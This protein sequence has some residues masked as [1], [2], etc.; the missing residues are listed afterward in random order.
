MNWKT[1]IVSCTLLAFILISCD[2]GDAVY[3][4]RPR[5][6][7][8]IDF[9]DKKYQKLNE[10]CPFNFE[11]PVYARAKKYERKD[12]QPCWYNIEFPQF[13]ATIHLSYKP[14]KKNIA[15]YIDTSHYF[16]KTHQ[17]RAT[18][19]EETVVIR[20]SAKVYGLLFSID[21]NVAS[22]LQF[23][24][25]DSTR[26]FLRGSL[27]FNSK[28]NIDSIKVVLDFLKKDILHLINT[29]QWKKD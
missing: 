17:S 11:I 25:T 7:F 19:I 1:L 16:A 20:D 2:E 12:A 3:S 21:G 13:K 14:V 15:N 23:Y 24:L 28:P 10:D 29:T 6:Y 27:Y 8:R 5:G 9:P 18:G 26:H 22:S 4:P